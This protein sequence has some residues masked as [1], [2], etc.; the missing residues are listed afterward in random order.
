LGKRRQLN[1]G[2]ILLHLAIVL[3]PL[4]FTG[5]ANAETSVRI[6]MSTSGSIVYP[7]NDNLAIIPD[8]WEPYDGVTISYGTGPQ[9][10][11]LDTAVTHNGNPSIRLESH[12][13]NDINAARETNGR[14]YNIKPGD[15]IVFKCWILVE[16]G[17]TDIQTQR[18][19]RI[20]MDFYG[21][22]GYITD[23]PIVGEYQY[24][25]NEIAPYAAASVDAVYVH[26]NTVGWV[27][28]TLDFIVPAQV[29]SYARSHTW[30]VPTR[31]VAWTQASLS[32]DSHKVWFSEAEMYINPT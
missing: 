4:F 17:S 10:C 15:H 14:W 6:N 30:E 19:A 3:L 11:F 18:G 25:G 1:K 12:T 2:V 13:S 26:W 22:N 23:M 24:S 16:P 9:I 28:R 20:G 27:Q 7:L 31:I 8:D 21:A 32:T 5:L 29:Y